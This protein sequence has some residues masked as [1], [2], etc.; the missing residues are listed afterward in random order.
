MDR[1]KNHALALWVSAPWGETPAKGRE[2]Y[3]RARAVLVY[4]RVMRELEPD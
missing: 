4:D 3:G 2:L 1:L